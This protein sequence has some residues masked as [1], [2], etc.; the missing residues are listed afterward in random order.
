MTARFLAYLFEWVET[1]K[2][3]GKLYIF[4]Q[5]GSREGN[6]GEISKEEHE[7]ICKTI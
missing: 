4:P 7:F 5:E 1:G 2:A 3:Q 6:C